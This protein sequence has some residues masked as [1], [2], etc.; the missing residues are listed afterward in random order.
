LNVL[1]IKVS[2]CRTGYLDWGFYPYSS[3]PISFE[4]TFGSTLFNSV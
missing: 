4:R 2:Y 1:H 3:F